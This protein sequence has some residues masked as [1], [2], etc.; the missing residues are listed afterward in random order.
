MQ[1][2]YNLLAVLGP[3]NTGKTFLAFDR[4]IS[5]KSGIFGFPLRLLARENYDKA[6]E[7]LGVHRVALITGEEKILPKDAKY[8]FC[9]V[10][11]MPLN[12]EVECIA[13]DEVQLSSDFERG[14]IF[15][16]RILNLRGTLE[17]IFLGSLTIEK[18]LLILFPKIKIEK[19]ERFS[20]LSFLP[21]NSLSKL[22]PRSAIIAFN[23]NSVYEIAESL[24]I[25]K[26]GAA[27]VLGS[28]SPRTRNAQVEVYEDKKVD[29]LVATDAIGMGLNLN[30]QH[31]AFSSLQKYDGRYNRNL[32]KSELGQIAGRAGRYQNDGTFGSLKGAGR[33]DPLTIQSIENHNF[34]IIRKIYW[35]NSNIDFSSI[36]SVLNS[37][38]QLPIKN[39]FILK[40][41]AADEVNFRTLSQ[42]REIIPFLIDAIS[43]ELLWDVCRVPDFQKFFNDYY[44]GLLKNIFLTLMKNQGKLPESWLHQ[45]VMRLDSYDGGIEELS[46][47]ISNIRTWTYIANQSRWLKNYDFWQEKTHNIENNLSDHLHKSL[48]NRFVDFS[49]SFFFN[50]KNRGEE[51]IIEVDEKKSIKLNGQNYGNIKGFNLELNIPNSESLFSLIHVKKSIRSMI[52]EKINNFLKSPLDSLNFGDIGT[53]TLDDDIKIFWGDEPIGKLIKGVSV[54]TPNAETLNS[55]FLESDKKIL[56]KRKLQEWV[57]Q[58]I[59]LSLKPLTDIIDEN[60][61]SE[62]RAIIFNLF[63]SLGTMSALE[64]LQTIRNLNEHDK[65]C[66]SRLGIR[67]GV[68]FFFIPSLLKK[69][70]ME[71]NAILWKIFYSE[72]N[73][74]LYP[75]PK[76]GRV[77]FVAEIKMPDTYWL[78]IGYICFGNFAIRVDVFERVFFLAR[79][80]I[81]F[82]PFLESSDMM[83]PVGCTSDQLADILLFC[84]FENIKLGGDKKLFYL[85]QKKIKKTK[86]SKIKE[87]KLIN[88]K[89]INKLKNITLKIEHRKVKKE[90]KL[91]NIK[92]INKTNKINTLSLNIDSETIKKEDKA[93]PNSPFAV[94]EKLL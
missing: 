59:S 7:K 55:E 29:Y 51:V 5:H 86:K 81:K 6:V 2:N 20:K 85:K 61:S 15:T 69:F 53:L 71:L 56:I 52:E 10:E 54:F 14:H 39:I 88:I 48:T 84:D 27:V 74:K 73:N 58:K 8:F 16:D 60:I 46:I 11:S 50:T 31:I 24:R 66:I 22:G 70:P 26:G 23:I 94:L 28:L 72:K 49:A 36:N 12:I 42:D 77:S 68:K 4:L 83:N 33:L 90:N 40:K 89:P 37:F 63:N 30:I 92:K 25:H 41:N 47:K 76:D 79:Q 17:T 34:D 1:E 19:R 44:L 65:A 78:A 80:K 93:D 18:I 45:R 57:N 62:V 91:I 21:K 64:H 82:G 35:R 75:L 13:I 9:T 38:K 32:S 67:I 43:I 3:T 87:N